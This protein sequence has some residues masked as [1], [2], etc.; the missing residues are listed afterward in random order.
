MQ[1]HVTVDTAMQ[2]GDLTIAAFVARTLALG[3]RA[4]AKEFQAVPCSV[5]TVEIEK[6]G[7][8]GLHIVFLGQISGF[9][10]VPCSVRMVEITKLGGGGPCTLYFWGRVHGKAPGSLGGAV[11]KVNVEAA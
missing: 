7:G 5:R 2:S 8:A 11:C 6:L 10:A 4:L 9:Q 3:D 1:V